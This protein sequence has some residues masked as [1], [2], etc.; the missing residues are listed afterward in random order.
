MVSNVNYKTVAN[1][2]IGGNA[3][4]FLNVS[5]SYKEIM[6]DI[7]KMIMVVAKGE[8]EEKPKRKEI[9]VVAEGEVEGEEIVAKRREGQ[10]RGGRR[11]AD[12]PR[13]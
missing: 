8:V 5:I 12:G 13:R 2:L 1:S 6:V 11:N 4:S 7:Y 10:E 9:M 3:I